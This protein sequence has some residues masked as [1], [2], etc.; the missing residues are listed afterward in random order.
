MLRATVRLRE[1]IMFV[2][3]IYHIYEY[4]FYVCCFGGD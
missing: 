1:L 3:K 2:F 4:M